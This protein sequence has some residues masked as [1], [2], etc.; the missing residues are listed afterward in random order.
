M[1]NV[2]ITDLP[3]GTTLDGSE[4]LESVQAGSSV[5]ITTGDVKTLAST[6]PTL[7]IDDAT[8]NGVSNAAIL[9]HTT[10]GTPATGIG[11]GLSFVTETSTGNNEAGMQIAAVTTDATATSEDFDFVVKLMAGGATAA[12]VA[13]VSSTG[14]ITVTGNTL[15]LTT[16]KTPASSSDTGTAGEICWDASYLYICTATN[17]WTRVA[18][19]W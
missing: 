2:K 19:A 12:E 13:R 11:T 4:P 15:K 10:S 14:N 5:Q 17:T 9:R 8:N 16:S 6:Q 18:L 3:L 1:A 7:T